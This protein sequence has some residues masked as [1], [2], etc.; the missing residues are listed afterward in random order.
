MKNSGCEIPDW[1][2]RLENLT[3]NDRQRLKTRPMGRTSVKEAA[4]GIANAGQTKKKKKVKV[5]GNQTKADDD[6][7]EEDEEEWVPCSNE[8]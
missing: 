5:E 1:M 6:D 8:G 2:L 7:K 3:Q 4:L